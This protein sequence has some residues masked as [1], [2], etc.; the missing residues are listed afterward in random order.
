MG[1]LEIETSGVEPDL[2]EQ[3]GIILEAPRKAYCWDL[4]LPYKPGWPQLETGSIRM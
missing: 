3:P 1:Q 4:V 2:Q